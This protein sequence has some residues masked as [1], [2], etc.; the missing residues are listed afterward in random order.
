M[1]KIVTSILATCLVVFVACKK[2]EEDPNNVYW[3]KLDPFETE[4]LNSH[5]YN[6][7]TQIIFQDQF[8]QVEPY[9][10]YQK[11]DQGTDWSWK[12]MV[13]K[14]QEEPSSNIEIT[15]RYINI[16]NETTKSLSIKLPYKIGLDN[17]GKTD[18]ELPISGGGI[19]TANYKNH[20]LLFDTLA[21]GAKEYYGVYEVKPLKQTMPDLD[22]DHNITRLYFSKNFGILQYE[23]KNG[24]VFIKVN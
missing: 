3:S 21:I 15:Y 9:M 4:E 7:L 8:D 22:S 12:E 19:D 16:H 6:A 18:F 1:Q 11:T 14:S 17:W 5:P 10:F 2:E 23:R 13:F 24:S 20:L